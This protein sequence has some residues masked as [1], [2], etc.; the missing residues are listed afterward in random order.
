MGLT[1]FLAW[2]AIAR[3]AIK[4][5]RTYLEELGQVLAEF[6][7]GPIENSPHRPDM[8]E[9]GRIGVDVGRPEHLFFTIIRQFFEHC[10]TTFEQLLDNCGARRYR[11]GFVLGVWRAHV[12]QLQGKAA[13]SSSSYQ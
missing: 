5:L 13:R 9:L 12:R 10:S 2:R 1:F 11:W 6:G 4:Q 8:A 3:Q 7:F